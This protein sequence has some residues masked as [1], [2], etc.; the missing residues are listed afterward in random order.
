MESKNKIV[1]YNELDNDKLIGLLKKK[2]RLI[3]LYEELNHLYDNHPSENIM[4][5][6]DQLVTEVGQLRGLSIP[7]RD[8]M[9]KKMVKI[10]DDVFRN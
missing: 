10:I 3:K 9:H 4:R 1:N 5:H 7:K 2:D 8:E 6:L